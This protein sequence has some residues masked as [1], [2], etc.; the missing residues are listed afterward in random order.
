MKKRGYSDPYKWSE[1]NQNGKGSGRSQSFTRGMDFDGSAV[2]VRRF[3]AQINIEGNEDDLNHYYIE[4]V[5]DKIIRIQHNPNDE[6]L[7]PYNVFLYYPRLEYWWGNTD[8]EFVIPHE[9]F[10]NLIMGLKADRALNML[11]QYIFHEKGVIDPTD[12]NNRLINGGLIPVDL[13]GGREL[14]KVLHQFRPQDDSLASTD[15]IMRE[16][17]ESQ[18]K[19]T[20]TP[21]FTRGAKAGGLRNQTA[22]AA[23]I[24]EEQGD[25]L[26]SNILEQFNF[27]M[28]ELAR[29]QMTMLQQH[30]PDQFGLRP[31]PEQSMRILDK[32]QILGS[33]DYRVETALTRN[34][35]N[36]LQRLQN[37]ITGTM[38]FRGTGDPTWQ[39]V[40]MEQVARR[41]LQQA[42]IGP[43]DELLPAGAPAQI[44]GAVPSMQMTG[45]EL[46]G[47]AT[48][49]APAQTPQAQLQGVM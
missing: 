21:D 49:A 3:Y 23:L 18:Q 40:D 30:L 4:M 11:Q 7:V 45:A 12:W 34:R 13:K 43:V 35:L 9:N 14:Q 25:A 39:R 48:P 32:A 44:P 47:A 10:T 19:M 33:F 1:E 8:S 5:G 22:T 26:E 2:D 42:D 38:N 15:S 46:G 41:W 31:R 27:S 36:E 24:L 16:V 17:K 37:K 28:E 20:P 29:V 6:D